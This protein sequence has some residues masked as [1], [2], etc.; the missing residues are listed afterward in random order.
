MS[1]P[2]QLVMAGRYLSSAGLTPGT[3]GNLSV[4][5]D[6]TILCSPTGT[7]LGSLSP[8]ALSVLDLQGSLLAGPSPTKESTMH[9]A[10]YRAAAEVGA[11]VHLHSTCAAAWSALAG[12]DPANALPPLT[13]YLTMKAG[14]VRL[15]PYV[16]PGGSAL[17][18]YVGQALADG[19]RAVLLA[20]HGSL[21]AGR[22]LDDAVALAEE[23]EEAAKVAFLVGNRPARALDESQVAELLR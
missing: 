13:P 16:R 5:Q 15:V 21:V 9:A 12:L 4:R 23:V 18:E 10:C 19:Y 3:T 20:N 6:A 7:R 17:Q 14:R 22:T 11:V 2:E 8:D 1:M